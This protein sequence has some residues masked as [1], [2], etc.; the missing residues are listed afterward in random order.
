MK[1]DN[2]LAPNLPGFYIPDHYKVSIAILF[3][4]ICLNDSS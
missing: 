3:T 4:Q 2:K 1:E